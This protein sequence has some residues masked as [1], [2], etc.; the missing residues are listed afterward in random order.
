MST[1][2]KHVTPLVP[3]AH[4]VLLG[5]PVCVMVAGQR[6][7]SAEQAGGQ[8]SP[9]SCTAETDELQKAKRNWGSQSSPSKDKLGIAKSSQQEKLGIAKLP[10]QENPRRRVPSERNPTAT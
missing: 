2:A 4:P 7:T 9:T 1:K 5:D 8:R 3:N 10:Q 6:A